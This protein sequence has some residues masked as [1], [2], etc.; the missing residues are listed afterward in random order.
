MLALA[1]C[2]G[3][4]TAYQQPVTT[5]TP[6]NTGPTMSESGAPPPAYDRYGV[7]N[8]DASGTYVGGHG[9]GATVDNPDQT[10]LGLPK[11]SFPDM[12]KMNCTG[13][14]GANAGTLSCS[15]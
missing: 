4:P 10:T 9:I 5:A 11:T 12:S 15:N 14:S 3:P 6:S 8:Y 13:S 1:G 2:G 7:A